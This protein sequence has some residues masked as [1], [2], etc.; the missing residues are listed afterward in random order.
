MTKDLFIETINILEKQYYKD[1]EFSEHMGN[2]FPCAH[3]ANLLP[4]NDLISSQLVLILQ[5]EMNDYPGHDMYSWITYY[6]Y[7]L[8]FGKKYTKG[9]V[10]DK[11]GSEIKLS[12]VEELYNFLIKMKHKKKIT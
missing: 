7:E 12:N 10:T 4:D 9:S 2:A 3:P 5:H 1:I 11:D 6:C 8:E